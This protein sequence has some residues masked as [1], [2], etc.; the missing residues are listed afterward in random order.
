MV[1]SIFLLCTIPLQA[2]PAT[3]PT[4]SASSANAT[5]HPANA[6]QIASWFAD[7]ANRDAT[8]RD[9]ARQNLMGLS[10]PDL[11]ILEYLVKKNRSLA[12]SQIVALRDI[13]T[14]VFLAGQTYTAVPGNSGFLGVS[15]PGYAPN[16][17]ADIDDGSP[18]NGIVILDRIPGFPGYRSLQNGDIIMGATEMG[19]QAI[20][21]SQDF[22]AFISSCHQ[23]DT[24]HLKILRAGQMLTIPVQLAARPDWHDTQQ[25]PRED[26]LQVPEVRHRQALADDYWN[27]HFAAYVQESVS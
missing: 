4:T 26:I 20:N 1:A 3:H 2:A 17:P 14:Q 22:S 13:V 12:P 8:R 15:F 18:Q 5:T 11:S 16:D 25:F 9:A 23:G 7:L 6:N 27:T 19:D 10:P 24:V 21:R